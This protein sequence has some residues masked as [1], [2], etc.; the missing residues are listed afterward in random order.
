MV[1]FAIFSCVV[2]RS[3]LG[4]GSA[5]T[6]PITICFKRVLIESSVKLSMMDKLGGLQRRE[7]RNAIKLECQYAHD[8][9]DSHCLSCG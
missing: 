2:A 6:C 9:C 7:E 1:P 4:L 5:T 3:E 8:V